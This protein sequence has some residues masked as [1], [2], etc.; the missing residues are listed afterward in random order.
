MPRRFVCGHQALLKSKRWK[1]LRLEAL[2]RDGWTCRHCGGRGWLEVDH[3][4][5]VRDRPDLAMNL[6]N[7]Q[8]LWGKYH[9]RKTCVEVGHVTLSPDRAAWA[10]L[11]N[12]DMDASEHQDSTPLE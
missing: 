3:I 4:Q 6:D 11:L 8:V 12:G 5:P 1:R 7:I 10:A 9:T 2:R